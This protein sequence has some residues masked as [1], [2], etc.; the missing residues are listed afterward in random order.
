MTTR[1]PKLV[2][3]NIRQTLDAARFGYDDLMGE[4]PRRRHIGLR[5]FVVFGRAVTN[6]IQTLRS[7]DPDFD[8]WYAPIQADLRADP[9][10]RYFYQLR[11]EILKEGSTNIGIA[12][13]INRFNLADL[14]PLMKNPP[15]GAQS[16]FVGDQRG[17]SGWQIVNADGSTEAYY[18]ALPD[19]I[20]D[21]IE[22]S[23]MSPDLPGVTVNQ[24]ATTYLAKLNSLVVQTTARYQ[25]W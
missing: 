5:N 15:P 20:S 7:V 18:V 21:G 12:I 13:E 24:A 1:D 25:S 19:N 8:A 4:D 3:E 22:Y 10:A 16:F 23:F 14:Q 6:V 11:S 9:I 17:G 2:L